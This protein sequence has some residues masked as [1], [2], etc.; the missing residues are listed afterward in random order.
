MFKT[1]ISLIIPIYRVSKYLSKCLDSLLNQRFDLPYNIILVETA[2]DDG[3]DLICEK[4]QKENC[5]KVYWFHYPKRYS[6][7]MARNLGLL[8]S[9]GRFVSFVDG[10]DL[11]EKDFLSTLYNEF[12]KDE[13]LQIAFSGYD[14]ISKDGKRKKGFSGSFCGRG[15]DA[16][17]KYLLHQPRF[18]GYCRG[19]LY[20]RSFLYA[21]RLYFDP[22]MSLYEDELF[23]S[24]CLFDASRVKFVNSVAYHYCYHSS[25]TMNTSKDWLNP[26]LQCYKKIFSYIKKT[27][28]EFASSLFGRCFR[29]QKK[30]LKLDCKNSFVFLDMSEKELFRKCLKSYKEI[31]R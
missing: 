30:Q 3:S 27:D 24:K 16:L 20:R 13:Q 8:H 26:H 1:E 9:N 17:K 4:Y 10:D 25:S 2:S 7:S 29:A 14:V 11:V 18:R 19:G 21:N 23:V 5:D 6:V 15:R 31:V 12:L 22:E 28:F